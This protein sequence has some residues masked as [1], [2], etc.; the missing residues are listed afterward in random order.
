MELVNWYLK[1]IWQC[2][3]KTRNLIKNSNLVTNCSLFHQRAKIKSKNKLWSKLVRMYSNWRHLEWL[4]M[5][6]DKRM[7]S[8][9]Y[10]RSTKLLYSSQLKMHWE[11]VALSQCSLKEVL[12]IN[13]IFF[14]SR[15]VSLWWR[16]AL[17]SILDRFPLSFLPVWSILQERNL[18]LVLL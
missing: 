13:L 14:H 16:L 15:L 7:I 5:F 4:T 8:R 1:I 17:L 12:M 3:V 6:Q 18:D 2:L 11:L 10:Q 9:S